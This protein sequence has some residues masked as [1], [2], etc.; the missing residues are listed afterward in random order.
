MQVTKLIE[1]LFSDKKASKQLVRKCASEEA[2]K[3]EMNCKVLAKY[4]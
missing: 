4:L 3:K 2:E 1:N